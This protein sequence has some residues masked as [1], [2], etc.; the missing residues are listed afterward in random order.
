MAN[1]P[2]RILSAEIQGVFSVSG[3]RTMS[4]PPVT[5]YVQFY[6]KSL[7][8]KMARV[9]GGA[10]IMRPLNWRGGVLQNEKIRFML[11]SSSITSQQD[12][13]DETF[14]LQNLK[15]LT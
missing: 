8:K 11:F 12:K 10:N 14:F 3:P 15:L 2:N 4:P 7:F 5:E 1:L 13:T 6:S 9:S